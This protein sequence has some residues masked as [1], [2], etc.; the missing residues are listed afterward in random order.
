MKIKVKDRYI[1]FTETNFEDYVFSYILDLYNLPK[2]IDYSQFKQKFQG[3]SSRYIYLTSMNITLNI[4][5]E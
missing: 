1:L 5:R 2:M 3:I 4:K